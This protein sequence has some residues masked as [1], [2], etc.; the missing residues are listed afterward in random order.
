MTYT[1]ITA[2]SGGAGLELIV[3]YTGEDLYSISLKL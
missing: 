3:I 1:H 2:V